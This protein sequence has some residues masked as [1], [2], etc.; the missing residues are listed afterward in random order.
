MKIL[1]FII[2]FFFKNDL[3]ALKLYLIFNI[4]IIILYFAVSYVR[5]DRC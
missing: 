5:I 1:I 4:I 3:Y 2:G